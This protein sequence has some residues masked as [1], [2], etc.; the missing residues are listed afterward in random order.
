MD[1]QGLSDALHGG[2]AGDLGRPGMPHGPF[3]RLLRGF[4][5]FFSYHA[6]LSRRSIRTIQAARFNLR[7]RPTVFHPWRC[8]VLDFLEGHEITTMATAMN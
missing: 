1:Q 2:P 3:R 4:I 7:V 5:H 8:R 6:I